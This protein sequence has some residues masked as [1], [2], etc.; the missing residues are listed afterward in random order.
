[1][2]KLLPFAPANLWRAVPSG[3]VRKQVHVDPAKLL[4]GTPIE[5][6]HNGVPATD[7]VTEG[8]ANCISSRAD[9][10]GFLHMPILDVDRPCTPDLQDEFQ[11]IFD[12]PVH[13]V[14]STN[15]WHVYIDVPPYERGYR[16][17]SWVNF[18]MVLAVLANEGL[19]DQ[20][21]SYYSRREE[22]CVLRKPGLKKVLNKPTWSTDWSCMWCSKGF[23]SEQELEEH[24]ATC[25]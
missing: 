11:R 5:E 19:I 24:E 17:M 10:Q 18:T 20:G 22:Q 15:F 8:F 7:N 12:A 3:A 1:M 9:M 2:S 21:W 14:P 13:W 6:Y 16:V 23:A 4:F 25:E